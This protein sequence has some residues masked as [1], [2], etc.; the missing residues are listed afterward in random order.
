MTD[1]EV[2]EALGE[3][4]SCVKVVRLSEG[5]RLV[6]CSTGAEATIGNSTTLIR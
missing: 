3:T 2:E 1:A 4:G 6:D 5:I